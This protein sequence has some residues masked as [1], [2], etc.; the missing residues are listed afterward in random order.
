MFPELP[1][2]NSKYHH[3]AKS[4]KK[5]IKPSVV[6]KKKALTDCVDESGN[7]RT[8]GPKGEEKGACHAVQV[9]RQ[10]GP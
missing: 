8:D 9:Q 3:L 4:L 6:K 5:K 2:R 1:L 7:C 10:Q